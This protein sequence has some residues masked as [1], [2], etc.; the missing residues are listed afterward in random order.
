MTKWFLCVSF[1][2]TYCAGSIG[3]KNKVDKIIPEQG[4]IVAS[5][6][7]AGIVK[8]RN[9]YQVYSNINGIIKKIYVEENDSV[10]CGAALFE[11]GNESVQLNTDRAALTAAFNAIYSNEEKINE[12]KNNILLAQSKYNIDSLNHK[13]QQYLFD[14]NIGTRN[15][16][17]Q[18]QL[19]LLSSKAAL[20]SARHT[21][22]SVIKQLRFAEKL[23][24][25]ELQISRSTERE[26]TIRSEINGKVY[27]V[28]K[29]EGELVNPAMPIAVIGDAKNFYVE[30][31]V[32]ELDISR[33]KLNQK[34]ALSLD[35]YSGET[36]D[37]LVSKINPMMDE[38]TKTFTVEV[39][40][41]S[42]PL[43]LYPQLSVEA[44]III[45]EKSNTLIIP[46]NY[47][48]NDSF[49]LCGL[50]KRRVRTG[51]KDY[52]RVEIISGLSADDVI[53]KPAK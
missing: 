50:E 21:Y 7:A 19:A 4:K 6:Y 43:V 46:R 49:V 44:S 39:D 22:T 52:E 40:F 1:S 34:V 16:L 48:V 2:L 20:E 12:L 9:Q 30:L 13:R 35:S 25:N 14:H 41:V 24:K 5:V 23:S 28:L 42:R 15:E 53:H 33:I 8:S 36:F 47:L 3:C 27:A 10:R 31:E 26:Y 37:G 18:R 29:H 51:I 11:I 38:R 17:E 32:D 45:E